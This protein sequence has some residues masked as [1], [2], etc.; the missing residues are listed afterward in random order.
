MPNAVVTND[1]LYMIVTQQTPQSYRDPQRQTTLR[2]RNVADKRDDH[3]AQMEI[4]VA[5]IYPGSVRCVSGSV[6]L[7]RDAAFELAAT[8]LGVGVFTLRDRMA[9]VLAAKEEARG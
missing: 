8:L 3:F 4:E 7:D 6:Q 2:A 9:H 5:S 1:S